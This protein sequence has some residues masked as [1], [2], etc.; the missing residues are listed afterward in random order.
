MT[1]V[2]NPKGH[3]A[4]LGTVP[5]A[6]GEKSRPVRVR[7]REW[8]FERLAGMSAAEVGELIESALRG[9]DGKPG[10]PSAAP[11]VLPSTPELFPV[12][13]KP[14][15]QQAKNTVSATKKPKTPKPTTPA[16]PGGGAPGAAG[17]AVPPPIADQ[18]RV[19]GSKL[20]TAQALICAGLK[21]P[22]AVAEYDS[23][24]RR[25][26][27]GFAGAP[28]READLEELARMGVLEVTGEGR[29]AVYKLAE[30]VQSTPTTQDSPRKRGRPRKEGPRARP[31]KEA[32]KPVAQKK[33]QAEP[34]KPAP[35]RL[36]RL[37]RRD[38]LSDIQ[39][40]VVELLEAGGVLHQEGEGQTYFVV[41]ERGSALKVHAGTIKTMIRT[42]ILRPQDGGGSV[43]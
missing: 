13:P 7:A 1:K 26:M 34:L 5:L 43:R 35:Y 30:Q 24:E 39:R 15:P 23:Y 27:V 17:P 19:T 40:Y 4:T 20:S 28:A 38:L 12:E 25:W 42:G 10:K 41:N 33:P 22:G 21:L 11:A 37:P 31:K 9:L 14:Q 3:I 36:A 16:A 6:A 2:R 8:V 29:G 18:M 32:A